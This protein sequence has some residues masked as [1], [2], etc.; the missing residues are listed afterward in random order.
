MFLEPTE[1]HA[2]QMIE[3]NN[4]KGTIEMLEAPILSEDDIMYQ[5]TYRIKMTPKLGQ[6]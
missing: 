1:I 5:R 4:I 6:C 2:G 3:I